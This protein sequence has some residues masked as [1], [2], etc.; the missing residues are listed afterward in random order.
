MTKQS[1]AS[2]S[3][4]QKTAELFTGLCG[5]VSSDQAT[6]QLLRTISKVGQLI[7]Q[8]SSPEKLQGDICQLLVEHGGYRMAWIG[9]ISASGTEVRPVASA[10]ISKK[11]LEQ[12]ASN[13]NDSPL[14]CG[15][16]IATIHTGLHVVIEDTE[17]SQH[18]AYWHKQAKQL[19]Y[20]SS[21][22]IPL[23]N[24]LTIIGAINLYSP[25]PHAFNENEI[26]LLYGLSATIGL[27]LQQCKERDQQSSITQPSM[28]NES[29]LIEAQHIAQVGS[30]ELNLENNKL[31]WSDEIYRIFEITSSKFEASYEAF[32]QRVHPDDRDFVDRAY[33]E[34][35]NNQTLYDIEHRLLMPDGSIKYVV[36]KCGTIYDSTGK[37]IRSVGTVQDITA[38]KQIE[39]A[40]R[41]QLA[42]ER[43]HCEQYASALQDNKDYFCAVT[44]NAM[45]SFFLCSTDGQLLD[46]NK[47]ACNTLGYLRNEMLDKTLFDIEVGITPETLLNIWATLEKNQSYRIEGVNKRKDGAVFP[48]EFNF[49]KFTLGKKCLVLGVARDTSER[50]Q[51]EEGLIL[52]KEKAEEISKEKSQFLAHMSQEFLVPMSTINGFAQL[53]ELENDLKD[54]QHNDINH[55]LEASDQLLQLANKAMDIAK[56]DSGQLHIAI[57]P[58]PLD[59]IITA[60]ISLLESA[61]EK[62]R[63]TIVKKY[64]E[65]IWVA[66]NG[67]RIK[68]V[69]VN[70]LS[71]A[72][73]YNI[74]GGK[75]V[76]D[77]T[78]MP[79]D[80]VRLNVTDTGIGINP[81][82]H[83]KVF[84]PFQRLNSETYYPV[85]SGIG[86]MVAKK[87]M[88]EMS[89]SIGFKSTQGE[90]STFWI[91]LPR[92]S[93]AEL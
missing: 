16:S 10:G 11:H 85:G 82:M 13:A 28:H 84:Q 92:S 66:G 41:N 57:E 90:G 71:N 3:E 29:S 55:I 25:L 39:E 59:P 48:V 22:A 30:W 81:D 73:K 61:A 44:N 91:E 79:D 43:K 26:A 62:R 24:H 17:L 20:R 14:S 72:I 4:P 88:T 89:G 27:A 1:D 2:S 75:I 7:A 60:G 93:I 32:L 15:P 21:I 63:I 54:S 76:I 70:L 52:A 5:T 67:I 56:A 38:K 18:S 34:S 8:K 6:R 64:D 46:I 65:E 74:D 68:E 78:T 36:E 35:L 37:P 50:K 12:V 23:R 33:S 45:D 9:M 51:I 83:V 87:L 53:L 19:G 80:R 40:L 42:Q 58:T 77:C 86:L 47:Q 69:L 49:S 31:I